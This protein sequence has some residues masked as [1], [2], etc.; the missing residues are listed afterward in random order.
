MNF[1]DLTTSDG[2][3]NTIWFDHIVSLTESEDSQEHTVIEAIKKYV[4]N[5]CYFSSTSEETEIIVDFSSYSI[6]IKLNE[7]YYVKLQFTPGKP[8]IDLHLGLGSNQTA[9]GFSNVFNICS[10]IECAYDIQTI[11]VNRDEFYFT[12]QTV[13]DEH[14]YEIVKKINSNS[15]DI[16]IMFKYA[17]TTK[18]IK[19]FY[20]LLKL[21]NVKF[22]FLKEY[23]E[24][25]RAHVTETHKRQLL[26]KYKHIK[27][28]E[29]TPT[30]ITLSYV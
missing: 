13:I 20:K 11:Y 14:T 8:N 19:M 1:N 2:A 29:V 4:K 18:S 17:I 24:P 12:H 25:I 16:N 30:L 21:S 9:I 6:L 23:I 28:C 22:Y 26:S 5:L 3:F 15:H 7:L 10:I 27:Q